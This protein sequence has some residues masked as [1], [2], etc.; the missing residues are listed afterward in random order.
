MKICTYF[1]I[2]AVMFLS[3]CSG[4]MVNQSSKPLSKEN[5]MYPFTLP[6]LTYAYNSLEPYI[7]ARTMDI[8]HTKHHQAYIDNLNKALEGY[9]ELQKMSLEQLLVSLDKIPAVIRTAVRNNG[10]GH[11]AHSLFWKIIG[12]E[13]TAEPADELAKAISHDF[14]SFANFKDAFTKECKTF[15]GSGWVWLCVDKTKKLVIIATPGHDVPL[16][17]NLDPIMVFDVWE[18]AYYLKYQNRRADYIDNWWH[19]VNWAQVA[20]NYLATKKIS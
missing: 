13:T 19:V 9:P 5:R 4:N 8:H 20:E 18:H 6:P 1:S 3:S 17:Q 16:T 7:D 12:P 10:G 2:F 14:G 15:F 11:Y